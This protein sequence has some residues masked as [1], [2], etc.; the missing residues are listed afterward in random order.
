[1]LELR[2]RLQKSGD[3]SDPHHR[4]LLARLFDKLHEDF[5]IHEQLPT[6]NIPDEMA[7]HVVQH[8]FRKT[9]NGWP[10][11]QVGP[12]IL[13]LNETDGYTWGN[14]KERSIRILGTL[15]EAH[16]AP[17]DLDIEHIVLRYVDAVSLSQTDS[18]LVFLKQRMK[19]DI[20]LPSE[21]FESSKIPSKPVF[22]ALDTMFESNE[23]KGVVQLRFAT[24]DGANGPQLIWETTVQAKGSDVPDMPHD[25]PK[26][27]D[28]AHQITGDWFFKLIDGELLK[29]FSSV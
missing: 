16:P 12:G 4:L 19:I 21:L 11:V 25:F 3:G 28:N 7:D 15:F 1:M 5:P 8:R 14:F 17:S 24:V 27:I 6:A 18:A 23:P 9:T 20:S 2:W 22:L 10:L 26:W 29:R 13:T